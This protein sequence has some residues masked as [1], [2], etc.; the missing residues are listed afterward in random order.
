MKL[1]K[2]NQLVLDTLL[3][4]GR[5]MFTYNCFGHDITTIAA[6]AALASGSHSLTVEFAYDGGFGAGGEL[7]LSVDGEAVAGARLERTVPI[8]FSMSGE[9]FD[10]GVDTGAA[11]GP[12]PHGFRCTAEIVGVTLERLDDPSPQVSAAESAARV[13]AAMSTQ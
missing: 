6:P 3:D 7:V 2:N 13:R 12:Y 8:V 5:P 9:T 1:S 11:V 10:V 4:A